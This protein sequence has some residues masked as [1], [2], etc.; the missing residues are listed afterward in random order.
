MLKEILFF[1][2]DDD[3]FLWRK[4][5]K[6]HI[7]TNELPVEDLSSLYKSM[8]QTLD[9]LISV[10]TNMHTIRNFPWRLGARSINIAEYTD[11][12]YIVG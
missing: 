4:T 6:K 7:Q 8:F 1:C 5:E 12:V 3:S 10:Y 9:S 11:T 2:I